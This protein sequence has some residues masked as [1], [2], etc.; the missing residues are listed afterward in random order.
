MYFC[1]ENK[2]TNKKRET[3]TE[4][5][6]STYC[7]W[8]NIWKSIFLM[9]FLA[10]STVPTLVTD[11]KVPR[12]TSVI[13]LSLKYNRRIKR[14][15]RNE[16]E[17]SLRSWLWSMCR[18]RSTV[19]RANVPL[20]HV[21]IHTWISV[22]TSYYF[23]YSFQ[24][25]ATFIRWWWL[26]KMLE[27]Q[28]PRHNFPFASIHNGLLSSDEEWLVHRGWCTTRDIDKNLNRS[29]L[30][31]TNINF[32]LYIYFNI[33]SEFLWG[34]QPGYLS[35]GV[36]KKIFIGIYILGFLKISGA[37]AALPKANIYSAFHKTRHHQ[38]NTHV[39]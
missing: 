29:F 39:L 22:E 9:K 5:S 7:S 37:T 2:I 21:E 6:T 30:K 27:I 24:T 18:T 35:L 1:Y 34:L 15:P 25:N 20:K 38:N 8:L 19:F 36:P 17:S 4:L 13:L 11:P 28:G 10:R 16:F 32:Y 12:P 31:C 23:Q 26:G 33:F 3:C 14:I